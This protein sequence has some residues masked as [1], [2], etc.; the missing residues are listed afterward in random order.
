MEG[1]M[2]VVGYIR[3]SSRNEQHQK[4]SAPEQERA[5]RA[6][7]NANGHRLVEVYRDVGV[8]GANG[9]DQREGLPDAEAAIQA[10]KADGLVV[11]ELDR[12]H[13]DML[14]QEQVLADLWRIRP[15]VEV[16][17]T[18]PGEQQNLQ[19]D[20]PSDP[21]RRMIRQI[22]GAVAEYVRAQTVARLRAGKRRKRE[23]GGYIGG[24]PAFGQAAVEKALVDDEAERA[25]IRRILELEQGGLSLR[26]MA[27]V[28][29]IEGRVAKRGGRWHPQTVARVLDRARSTATA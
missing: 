6:W 28:L 14:I 2:R 10:G 27:A 4:D 17:S 26:Q 9:L 12:L 23:A 13:R 21:S 16:F 20:D 5:I 3:V 29:E 18:K 1:D 15:E 24:Q 19:R 7:C 11:R 8:S 25:T 22:L